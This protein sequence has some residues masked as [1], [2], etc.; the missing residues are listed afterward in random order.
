MKVLYHQIQSTLKNHF[1]GIDKEL[2]SF[3]SEYNSFGVPVTNNV[4]K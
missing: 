2:V 3:V 4:F 1:S